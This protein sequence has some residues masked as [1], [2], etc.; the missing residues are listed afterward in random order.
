MTTGRRPVKAPVNASDE[1]EVQIP[2]V[3]VEDPA[4][5]LQVAGRDDSLRLRL[6]EVQT[7]YKF[8]IDTLAKQA[9]DDPITREKINHPF[10][11]I[12]PNTVRSK[13][14]TFTMTSGKRL[15]MKSPTFMNTRD[16]TTG[17][18]L[19]LILLM[20]HLGDP[21]YLWIIGLLF[22][23]PVAPPDAIPSSQRRTGSGKKEKAGAE[24]AAIRSAS[25]RPGTKK[26]P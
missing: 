23:G 22:E 17:S 20:K 14:I 1:A 21:F 10:V 5:E 7:L 4:Q 9:C 26:G 3:L 2:R 11:D 19:A 13:V 25:A 8:V 24:G 15:P 18:A 12:T 16:M 6:I